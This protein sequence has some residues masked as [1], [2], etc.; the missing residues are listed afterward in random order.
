MN[1][2]QAVFTIAVIVLFPAAIIATDHYNCSQRK[3]KALLWQLK[4]A[5][6]PTAE[7]VDSWTP[8]WTMLVPKRWYKK[9]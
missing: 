2:A 7:E 6:A 1:F 4:R 3:K 5:T 8:I 9:A